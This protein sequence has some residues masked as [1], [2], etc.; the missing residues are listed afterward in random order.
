MEKQIQDLLDHYEQIKTMMSDPEVVTDQSRY[1]EIAREF[2]R[3]EPIVKTYHSLEKTRTGLQ[4]AREIL[5]DPDADSEMV[6]LAQMEKEELEPQL[7][8]LEKDLELLLLPPDPLD[9]KNIIMELRAGAGGDEAGLFVADLFR[10]YSRY[11]DKVGWKTETLSTSETGVGGFK[12]LSFSISGELV[13][14]KLKFESGVHRVQR[15][16]ATESSGRI[17]TSTI[18]VAVMPEVEEV[19]FEINPSDVR[20][21]TFCASG[22]GGQSVNTTYSAVRLTHTP[23]GTVVS[24]QDEKSQIKNKEK[25]FKVLRARLAEDERRRQEAKYAAQRSAQVGTGDRSEKIRTY[26]YPQ[27]RVSDHRIGL[28]VHNL[29]GVL[30]GEVDSILDALIAEEH[31]KKLEALQQNETE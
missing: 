7:E 14:S 4:D 10:M 6:E 26:N 23:T 19:D 9:D 29:S 27:G 8:Q 31:R 12:E 18:T 24:C 25:A 3:C 30:D 16:P 5:E 15:V 13:Y 1:R 22:P 21:D 28:T 11:A 17:H 2:K 20:I